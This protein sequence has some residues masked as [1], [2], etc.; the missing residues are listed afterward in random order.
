LEAVDELA[1]EEGVDRTELSRRLLSD[2]LAHRRVA[3]AIADYAAGRRTAWSAAERA[4]VDLY[5]MLDRIAEAGLP[6]RL[7]AEALDRLKSGGGPSRP[8][9]PS[10]SGPTQ[11]P[12]QTNDPVAPLRARYRPQSVRL[13]FV[14]ESS[15]ANGSHFYLAN[16]NLYRATREAFGKGLSVIDPPEGPAF[17]AWF[18]ELGCWLVDLADGPVNRSGASERSAAVVT[19]I[20]QLAEILRES[21]PIRV[22]V[23]LRRIAPAARQAAKIA[24]FD[25]RAIDVLP[26]PTRQ[27]RPVFVDQLAG[28]LTESLADGS[29]PKASSRAQAPEE[30]QH[31]IAEAPLAYGTPRLHE[32]MIGVLAGHGG[33][34]L[35]ASAIAREIAAGDLWRR[36]S[37]GG[38]PPGS[39]ISARAR[40]YPTL[41]QTSDLGIRQRRG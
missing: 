13:L 16:S 41:F 38:H 19:G 12:L 15:P 29:L 17:L 28:I 10:G 3:G 9:N 40:Q 7:D 32:V 6:Y 25:D 39:Q 37:D 14:G 2:G 30:R 27:W 4:G 24:G 22:L 33:G 20:P 5:E 18:R 36:P 31:A 23:V 21:Q 11:E 34:W 1:R 8:T 26:F 35:K